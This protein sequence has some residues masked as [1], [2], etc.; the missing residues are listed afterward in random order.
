MAQA[1]NLP[2]PI[3]EPQHEQPTAAPVTAPKQP[4]TKEPSAPGQPTPEGMPKPR[5][6]TLPVEPRPTPRHVGHSQTNYKLAENKSCLIF[7]LVILVSCCKLLPILHV[8]QCRFDSDTVKYTLKPIRLFLESL[9][10]SKVVHFFHRIA[11]GCP[12]SWWS[13]VLVVF[14]IIYYFIIRLYRLFI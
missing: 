3:E 8:F 14:F 2:I 9:F 7:Y 13:F 5:G 6:P 11:V 12:W 10:N 4:A 1:R